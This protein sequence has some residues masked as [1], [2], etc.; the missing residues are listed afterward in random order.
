M[1]NI[2][3]RKLIVSA[4]VFGWTQTHSQST[5]PNKPIK[6]VH[7]FAAGS[8]TDNTGRVLA[9]RL[10]QKLGQP[11]IVDNKP[12]ANMI[13]GSE[14]AAKQAADGYTMIMVTLDN[15]G[16]NP[17]LYRNPGYA[18][19]D[20]D[21]LTLIG[22]QPLVLISSSGFKY[23]SI[24]DLRAAA[25]ASKQPFSF[26]TWG[27]GSVAH[28]YGELLKSETGIPL[29]FIPYGGSAPATVATLGGHVDLTLAS[30][31]TSAMHVKAGNA[32][33]LAIGGTTRS[34]ELPNVA[35]FVEQGLPNVSGVQW[36]GIAVRAGGNRDIVD[37]LFA[38]ISEVLSEP[39]T[40]ERILKTGYT[41]IDGRSPPAFANFINAEAQKWERIVKVSGVTAER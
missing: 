34:S 38:A 15:M 24:Q 12:G 41:G 27:V 28:M 2:S 39:A 26:G 19:K 16:I 22:F 25:V 4:S 13:L 37:K 32:R 18:V 14:Y 21:P 33:A 17:N 7:A 35:T 6:L 8:G 31:F 3:R 30:L 29:N 11:V 1:N 9:E 40:R 36:H 20:F 5:Y 23:A 10:S